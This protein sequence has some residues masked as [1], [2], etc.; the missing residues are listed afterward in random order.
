[1]EINIIDGRKEKEF[2]ESTKVLVDVFR[3]TTTMPYIFRGGCSKIIPTASIK[4]ARSL[5]RDLPD[6]LLIGERYGIRIRGF[7]YNNS[8]YEVA[9]VDFTGKTVI[10]TSTNGTRVLERI[11]GKGEVFIASFVN[12]GA[13]SEILKKEER[14]DIVLSNRPDGPADEDM[15]FGQY[16]RELL[17]GKK[18]DREAYKKKIISSKGAKRLGIMGG[19][20]D[21]EYTMN[22]DAVD[23]PIH[24]D[25]K[26]I[27]RYG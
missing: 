10:F 23:F 18:P 14:I 2:R 1:L 22:Y 4:E 11:K 17:E 20:H 15:F 7:D 21:I 8:P 12:S 25:G 3:S 13:T 24:F 9:D 5:K 19:K 26:Y 27:V 16:L 6:A